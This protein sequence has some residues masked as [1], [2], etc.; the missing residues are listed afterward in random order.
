MWHH[1][2][3]GHLQPPQV[4]VT[5]GKSHKCNSHCGMLYSLGKKTKHK[6]KAGKGFTVRPPQAPRG[7]VA[8]RWNTESQAGKIMKAVLFFAPLHH[9]FFVRIDDAAGMEF[10]NKPISESEKK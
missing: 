3:T 6:M 10:R 2:G 8:E 7:P 1:P 5:A 4:V 9:Q